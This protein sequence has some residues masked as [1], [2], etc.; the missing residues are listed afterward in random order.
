MVLKY[1]KII[2]VQKFSFWHSLDGVEILS[3]DA[4][5]SDKLQ[6]VQRFQEIQQP[7]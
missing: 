7:V 2:F 6:E 1:K 4:A 5:A 3:M